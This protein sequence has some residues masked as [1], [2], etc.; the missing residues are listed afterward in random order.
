MDW[1]KSTQMN[2]PTRFVLIQNRLF[3]R[4]GMCDTSDV[5]FFL[6]IGEFD[7]HLFEIYRVHTV[8]VQH[9]SVGWPLPGRELPRL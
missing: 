4:F 9:H 5:F 8:L 3:P 7:V 2:H 6:E 1:G